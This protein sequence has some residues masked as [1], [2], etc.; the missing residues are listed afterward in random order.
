M[1][2]GRLERDGGAGGGRKSRWEWVAAAVST[3]LVLFV[4]GT[5]LYDAL[6]RPQ[7]PPS[8]RVQ[9]DTVLQADGLWLVRFRARNHGHETAAAVKVQGELMRGAQ[10]VE[11][12]EAVLDYV[13]GRSVRHGGL[14]FRHDPRTFRLELRALGYQEP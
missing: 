7:T 2:E 8:V 1:R 5:M 9:A 12:S 3:L 14:F 11:T 13:P 10:S 6:A 4:I